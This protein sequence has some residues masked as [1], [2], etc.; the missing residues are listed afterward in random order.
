MN[1][2]LCQSRGS[3]P[4]PRGPDLDAKPT[5]V[6]RDCYLDIHCPFEAMSV[7]TI[8]FPVRVEEQF[9][10]QYGLECYGN[11]QVQ[12]LIRQICCPQQK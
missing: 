1:E 3:N 9:F 2:F 7:G 12:V 6:M 4:R 8:F 5:E 10:F 11:F